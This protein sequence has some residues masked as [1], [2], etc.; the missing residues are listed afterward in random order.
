[1]FETFGY[2][3]EYYIENKFIGLLNCEKDRETYGFFG[4]KIE[5]IESDIT[6]SNGRRIKKGEQ[7]TTFLFELC[8]KIN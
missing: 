7:V 8:D 4:K 6:L 5:T 1:M 3:K 2:F